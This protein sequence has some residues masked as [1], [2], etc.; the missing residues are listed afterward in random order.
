MHDVHPKT[1]L[2]RQYLYKVP[3]NEILITGILQM[4][5]SSE[6]PNNDIIQMEIDRTFRDTSIQNRGYIVL[7]EGS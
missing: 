1:K 4:A 2:L 7:T 6:T 5:Q 3:R